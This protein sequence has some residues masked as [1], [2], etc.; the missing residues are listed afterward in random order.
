MYTLIV[1]YSKELTTSFAELNAVADSLGGLTLE[2][3]IY[4]R[5]FTWTRPINGERILL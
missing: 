4:T 3:Q 5:V 1:N 2:Q